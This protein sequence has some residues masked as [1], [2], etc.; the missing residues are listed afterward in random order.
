MAQ[1]ATIE[2]QNLPL[3][4]FVPERVL[5]AQFTMCLLQHLVKM[6]SGATFGS[7]ATARDAEVAQTGRNSQDLAA[8]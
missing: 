2:R 8:H 6:A 1:I 7:A 5:L 4:F 3:A